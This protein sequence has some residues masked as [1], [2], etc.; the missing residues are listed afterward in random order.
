M[1]NPTLIGALLGGVLGFSAT[2]A[3]EVDEKT[4]L[5]IGPGWEVVRNNCTACHS[6]MLITQNH[7][8]RGHWEGLIRWMQETQGLWEFDRETEDTI[9]SYLVEYYGP[10]EHTRRAPLR[11]DQLPKNPYEESAESR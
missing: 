8:N 4:G 11:K 9:L 5:E 6:A 10:R 3:Q 2:V 7:G 1:R